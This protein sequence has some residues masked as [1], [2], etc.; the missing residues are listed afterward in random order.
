MGDMVANK[1][2]YSLWEDLNVLVTGHT[3]FKGAWLTLLL[4][5]L[6]CN[7]Y[8]ISLPPLDNCLY[9]KLN[10]PIYNSRSAYIDINNFTELDTHLSSIRPKIIFHLAAQ[11]I[12]S[13]GYTNPLNTYQTNVIGTLNLLQSISNINYP[14]VVIVVT[15]DKVYK[16]NQS[17]ISYRENDRLG[18]FGDPY[19]ASKACVEI[20]CNSWMES[21][22]GNLPHQNPNV[23]LATVRAGNV[24]G[25]G[26]WSFNRIV[27]D[28]MRS[29]YMNKTLIIKNPEATRPWQHVLDPIFGYLLLAQKL[30]KNLYSKDKIFCTRELAVNFGPDIKSNRSVLHLVKE[31]NN[32]WNC[33]YEIRQSNSSPK[34]DSN[35]HINSDL[36]YSM[37][38]WNTKWDF[39][40]TIE[41]TVYWYKSVSDGLSCLDLCEENIEDYLHG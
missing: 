14:C 29:I 41:R 27:P 32:I 21:F 6:K 24:I 17:V 22:I 9:S 8:G 35:L 23:L 11:S 18:G 10:N 3:G 36:A 20:L 2:D 25:G 34:E 37:L 12:V 39:K 30:Y 38:T 31:I 26:D 4:K 19:S 15:T 28:I 13:D 7:I 5:R 16:S 40:S 1:V 33:E